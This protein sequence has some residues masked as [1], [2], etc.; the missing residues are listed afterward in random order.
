MSFNSKRNIVSII[1]GIALLIA[2][3]IYVLGNSAPDISNIKSWA[4]AMLIFIGIGIVSQIIIMI[5]FQIFYSI[6]IAVKERDKDDA[7]VERIIESTVMED[8]RD[9]EINQKSS[10]VGYGCAGVAFIVALFSIA[11]GL[12]AV[13]GLNILLAGFFIGSLVEGIVGIYH[14]ERGM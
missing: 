9:K 14:Y 12:D 3:L 8:E 7:E 13:L 1:A 11:F 10:I 2:Y 6:G 5:L 4:I